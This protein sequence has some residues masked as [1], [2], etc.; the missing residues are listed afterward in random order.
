MSQPP[1]PFALSP[2]PSSAGVLTNPFF[3][4]QSQWIQN[5][6]GWSGN[7]VTGKYYDSTE[8]AGAALWEGVLQRSGV[9]RETYNPDADRESAFSRYGTPHLTAPRL[10]QSA[11]RV[12]VMDAYNR[13]CAITGESTL[14]ALEAAHILPFAERGENVIPNGMLMRSDFHR[15][16]DAGLVTVTPDLRIEVSTRIREEW[17]NGKAYYRLHGEPLR[18]LPADIALRPSADM[19]RWHND[20][21]FVA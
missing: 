19:L 8:P 17:F 3:W 16:F 14:P 10:G 15:L 5:P 11:F 20:N 7:I 12:V 1:A 21:R 6:P 9:A 4:P 13:R 2:P 18:S